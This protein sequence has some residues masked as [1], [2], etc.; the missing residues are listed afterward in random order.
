MYNDWGDTDNLLKIFPFGLSAWGNKQ[1]HTK[2]NST[3][4]N[5]SQEVDYTNCCKVICEKK[6]SMM[7]GVIHVCSKIPPDGFYQKISWKCG[8]SS[9]HQHVSGCTSKVYVTVYIFLILGV[10]SPFSETLDFKSCVNTVHF[11][12]IHSHYNLC[13]NSQPHTLEQTLVAFW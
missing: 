7:V 2:E 8:L 10:P 13:V 9:A 12:N 5:Q 4:V 3:W 1:V 6:I 11:Y